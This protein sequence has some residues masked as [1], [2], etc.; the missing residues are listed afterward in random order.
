MVAPP[1]FEL[2][3]GTHFECA[4]CAVLLNPRGHNSLLECLYRTYEVRTVVLG[5]LDGIRTHT[6]EIL[7]LLTAATLVYEAMKPD[8]TLMQL[9]G[10]LGSTLKY[11]A[12]I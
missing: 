5:S 9:D 11:A 8:V 12:N 7:S 2:G 6:T 4:G 10:Y 3:K 1:R